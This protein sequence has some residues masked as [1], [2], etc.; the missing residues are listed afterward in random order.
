MKPVPTSAHGLPNTHIPRA[1]KV[2]RFVFVRR[3]QVKKPLQPLYDGPYE[4]LQHGDKFFRLQIGTREDNVS[5]DRLKP[6]HLD[7]GQPIIPA[8]PRPRGRPR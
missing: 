2:C 6:A 7:P 3:D 8:V 4:V 1:L 5:I